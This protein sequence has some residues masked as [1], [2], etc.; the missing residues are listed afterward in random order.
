MKSLTRKNKGQVIVEY[1]LLMVIAVALATLLTKQLVNR[2]TGS[3][4]II[5]KAWNDILINI[6]K[7]VP[8]CTKTDCSP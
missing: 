2:S 5:I 4:G 1:L 7:D 8:D 3:P 6:A